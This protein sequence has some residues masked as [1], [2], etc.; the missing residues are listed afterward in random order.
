MI[1]TLPAPQN[2]IVGGFFFLLAAA[3]AIA[4]LGLLYKS[5]GILL[6]MYL[7]FSAGGMPFAYLSA[8]IAPPVGLL[9]GNP[10]WLV[11]LPLVMVWLLLAALGLEYAWRYPAVAV[12]PL[13]CV[14]PQLLA[15]RLSRQELFQV[16]LPWEPA[17]TW[18]LL[19]GLVAVAGTLLAVYLDRLRRKRGAQPR[20]VARTSR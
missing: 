19:H 2:V 13:L 16:A 8:L 18:V 3:L 6:A 1:R 14:L 20:A 4:P 11:M 12:S 17:G 7:A 5:L 10:D 15:A 9:S